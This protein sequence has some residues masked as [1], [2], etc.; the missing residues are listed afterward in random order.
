MK[1]LLL[2]I[3]CALFY[4]AMVYGCSGNGAQVQQQAPEQQQEQGERIS[5]VSTIFPQYDWVRQIIGE[6]NMHR[7]ELTL[8]IDT[9]TDLHSYNPS[10]RDILT[11]KTS[12]VFIYVGGDADRWVDDVLNAA[13]ANPDIVA[14]GLIETLGDLVI[15]DYDHDHDECDE[16]HEDDEPHA[17]EHV[18]LSL[19]LAQINCIAIAEMLAGLDPDNAEAY[20]A[21]LSEYIGKL[22][23][24]D[25]E[26]QAVVDAAGFTAMVFA[27][28]FPFR[29]MAEDYGLDYYAAFSGCSAETDAS[30]ATIISLANRL[31]QL[32]LGA[33]LVTECSDQSIAETVIYNSES[34]NQSILVLDAMQSVTAADV[35]NGASYTAIMESNLAVL[36]EALG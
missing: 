23:V 13:D 6:E 9:L 11:V 30:F 17:D 36:R 5:I 29:Y 4:A 22:S 15:L 3:L 35:Q 33:V 34:K 10:V 7:F 20:M 19:R 31:N 12:D 21:N 28:R 26:Y 24:L 32:G 14:I 25:S 18:W 2:I 8:L 27:S 16:E 1:R